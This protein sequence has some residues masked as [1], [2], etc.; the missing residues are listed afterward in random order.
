MNLRA[1]GKLLLLVV[2]LD[3]LFSC[4]FGHAFIRFLRMVLPGQLDVLTRPFLR[5]PAPLFRLGALAQAI[6]AAYLLLRRDAS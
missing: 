1:G 3:G 4:V 2:M 5:V 6:A